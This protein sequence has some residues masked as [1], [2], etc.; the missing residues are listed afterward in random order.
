MNAC[1]VSVLSAYSRAPNT[2]FIDFSP[3]SDEVFNKG[4][5]SEERLTW[6][7]SLE[8][9]SIVAGEMWGQELVA[10]GHG[11]PTVRKRPP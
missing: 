7:N 10:A 2:C 6:A 8:V 3:C 5:L 1:P 9:T 4:N 11:A